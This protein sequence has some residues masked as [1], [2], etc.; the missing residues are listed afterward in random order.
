MSKDWRRREQRRR[1]AEA[2]WERDRDRAEA[3]RRDHDAFY[4]VVA[5]RLRE[6]QIDPVELRDYLAGLP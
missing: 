2:Q 5:D 3:K 6:L 1:E 4:A